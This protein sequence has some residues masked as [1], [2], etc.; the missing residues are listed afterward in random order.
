[1][2]IYNGNT[3]IDVA[4]LKKGENRSEVL[5]LGLVPNDK[6][7][8]LVGPDREVPLGTRLA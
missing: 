5:I 2:P 7:V 3:E 4:S 1:M 8:V 6:E